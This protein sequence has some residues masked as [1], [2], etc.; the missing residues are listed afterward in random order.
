MN[1][2][3]HT[4]D[5]LRQWQSLPLSVKLSMT[6]QRIRD[7]VR[8]YGED[9]VYVAFSGGKDS[10]VL[11]DIVRNQ[12]GYKD[13]PGVF[14]DTGLEYP[15]IREFVKTYDN[16]EWLKPKMNFKAVI[17]KYG[18]P[19][20]SKEVSECVYGAKKYLQAITEQI[21]SEQT[22]R[23][24]DR[25]QPPYKYFYEKTCGLG[26][27]AKNVE[28]GQIT[29]I[30]N[31]TDFANMLNEKAQ[32][33]EG[34][35]NVRLALMMGMYTRDCQ[36]KARE[37][38]PNEDRS[39]YSQE[40]YK[41][42]LDAPF[43]ISSQC[44]NVMKK[45]PSHRYGDET[46]RKAITGQMADES[47][48]RTQ[49]WLANGCNGFDLKRPVSNPM[50][51]WTEQDVLKYILIYI[52]TPLKEAWENI[53]NKNRKKRKISRKYLKKNN[54]RKTA[55]CSVYG[56]IVIDYDKENNCDGQMNL[57]DLEPQFG[58]FEV[59]DRPLTTSGCKRTGCMF[60]GYGCHLEKSPT[61]FE[62][63]KITHPKQYDYIMRPIEQGGLNYKNVIDWINNHSD[64]NIKY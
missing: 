8:E 64:I 10:T 41:F 62:R 50:A 40:K 57:A 1:E 49:Q 58:S 51:F 29:S 48:L 13:V 47:R 24:T 52:D 25:Q 39:A 33:R 35:S 4:I 22:D 61:R 30:A 46:G 19:M 28:G 44:C 56:D 20:I 53:N 18:Y 63:M 34:G 59:A 37:T 16:I 17:D 3:K 43:D 38:I 26:K 42:F 9:G 36:I 60:C 15:E 32:S 55:I 6:K 27:Y 11:M 54:Y 7:W 2:S 31:S 5:E 14:V 12:C 45:E 21:N 23:Q